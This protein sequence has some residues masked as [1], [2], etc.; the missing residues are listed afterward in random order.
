MLRSRGF[1]WAA[2]LA[3]VSAG[4][5]FQVSGYGCNQLWTNVA[6][7]SF[8]FCSVL[9]CAGGTYVNFCEPVPLLVDC[10]NAVLPP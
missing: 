9:N 2:L 4:T 8:D 6:L 10:P 5:M 7:N 3:T 1:R